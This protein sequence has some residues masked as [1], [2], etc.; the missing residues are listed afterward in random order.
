MEN[1]IKQMLI[2]EP[3]YGFLLTTIDRKYVPRSVVPT[4]AVCFDKKMNAQLLVCKEFFDQFTDSEKLALLKHEML[5]LA[6]KHLVLSESFNDKNLFNIA[7]DLEVNGH[8]DG[9][10]QGGLMAIDYGFPDKQGTLWY[11]RQLSQNVSTEQTQDPAMYDANHHENESGINPSPT[12]KYNNPQEIPD[13]QKPYIRDGNALKM[14]EGKGLIDDHSVWKNGLDKTELELANSLI[15]S[16][17][18][19]TVAAVKSR[20]TIPSELSEIISELQKP[21]ERVFDWRKVLRR[22]IGNSYDERKKMSRRKESKRFSGSCG[23]KHMKRTRMLVGIDTSGSVSKK[24]LHEF[25]SELTYMYKA[26]TDIYVLECDARI[27]KQ[28]SFKPGCITEVSG[29]GGTSFDPV[30]D[31]YRDHYKEFD[32]LVYLTDGEA[33]YDHLKIPQNNMLW[34]ISSNGSKGNYPGKTLYIPKQ[35]N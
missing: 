13:E 12:A 7:A 9:L 30:I 23:T 29:R 17:L 27:H 1:I 35:N 14:P 15:D 11:Y 4:L 32:S 2:E 18:L 33:P 34:V 3:F 20:G 19:T 16:K 10:P 21:L 6:F 26:G 8:I 5:H 25:V 28:Y 22:F 24:E 31:F